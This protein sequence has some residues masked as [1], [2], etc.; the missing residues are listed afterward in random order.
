MSNFSALLS[1]PI[2][3]ISQLYDPQPFSADSVIYLIRNGNNTCLAPVTNYCK[4][5]DKN[6]DVYLKMMYLQALSYI[7]PL[8]LYASKNPQIPPHILPQH[9]NHYWNI[10]PQ[11]LNLKECPQTHSFTDLLIHS[12]TAYWATPFLK[13]MWLV[14]AIHRRKEHIP[15]LKI[16]MS[17]RCKI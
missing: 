6:K 10:F 5:Q 9:D 16:F 1:T 4:A 7:S 13:A 2:S 11:N 17:Q 8:D 3:V 15:A 12:T 14:G